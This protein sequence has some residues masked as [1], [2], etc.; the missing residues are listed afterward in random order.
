MAKERDTTEIVTDRTKRKS[1]DRLRQGER[2]TEMERDMDRED[3]ERGIHSERQSKRGNESE[4]WI[5]RQRGTK[6]K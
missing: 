1:E 2:E 5:E 3:G 4:R 6:T